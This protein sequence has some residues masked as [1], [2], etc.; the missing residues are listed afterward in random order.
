VLELKAMLLFGALVFSISPLFNLVHKQNIYF[1]NAL[2]FAGFW[3]GFY[4][5][6]F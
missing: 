3:A 5:V 2:M 4:Y 6:T 1:P